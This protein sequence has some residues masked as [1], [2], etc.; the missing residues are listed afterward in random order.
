MLSDF[1]SGPQLEVGEQGMDLRPLCVS[2]TL[3]HL[4]QSIIASE[5]QA[6]SKSPLGVA[7]SLIKKILA[8]ILGKGDCR[9]KWRKP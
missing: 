5:K 4:P 1:P 7:V 9:L 8:P 6:T 2:T 3:C